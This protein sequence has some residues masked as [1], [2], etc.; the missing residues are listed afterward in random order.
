M[1]RRMFNF[2]AFVSLLLCAATVV[3][4]IGFSDVGED[5]FVATGGGT[6]WNFSSS[7]GVL[8]ATRYVGWPRPVRLYHRIQDGYPFRVVNPVFAIEWAG[9]HRTEWRR[10]GFYFAHGTVCVMLGKDGAADYGHSTNSVIQ[11]LQNFTSQKF[12]PPFPFWSVG[13]P[14]WLAV[15]IFA[16]LPTFLV[17]RSAIGR[18][19]GRLR[20]S[21]GRCYKC[22][23]DL[24]GNTSGL[25][26][27][28]GSTI[29]S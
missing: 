8:C 3:L 22:G 10:G 28:C 15:V 14:C 4:W 21:L 11:M 18:L 23:Y 6:V 1:L 26:P 12:S 5:F 13:I 17:C 19:R 9:A 29:S 2:A 16:L 7:G 27:E 24:A 25:C 20:T